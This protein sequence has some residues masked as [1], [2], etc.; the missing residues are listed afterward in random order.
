MRR[1]LAFVV[2]LS[3]SSSVH[4]NLAVTSEQF[5]AACRKPGSAHGVLNR[6]AEVHWSPLLSA[7]FLRRH[8]EPPAPEALCLPPPIRE[9]GGPDYRGLQNIRLLLLSNVT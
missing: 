9:L 1:T 7:T 2:F 6:R 8:M 4:N 5:S 3:V